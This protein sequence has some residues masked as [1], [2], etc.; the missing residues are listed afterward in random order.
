MVSKLF[1]R[2]LAA[3]NRFLD[4][5]N[6]YA[7]FRNETHASGKG[8]FPFKSRFCINV[9]DD[10][11]FRFSYTLG[12]LRASFGMTC[13]PDEARIGTWFC[14]PGLS[15]FMSSSSWEHYRETIKAIG[16]KMLDL[17]VDDGHIRWTTPFADPD[18][19]RT[20]EPWYY[21]GA[22][23]L[24]EL[25]LGK[26]SFSREQVSQ[27]IAVTI[28][29]P[30]GSYAGVYIVERLTWD[31]PRWFSKS[32]TLATVRCDEGVPIPG[33]GEN[34]YD[35]DQDAIYAHSEDTSDPAQAIGQF[36]TSALQ[37]RF[38]YGGLNWKPEP[39]DPE[40]SPNMPSDTIPALVMVPLSPTEDRPS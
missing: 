36:V 33:K 28:P 23:D 24:G 20:D 19:H 8:E 32:K 1:N 27:P 22:I 34:D 5:H 13:S 2:G 30:E 39:Q 18:N 21:R 40:S 12:E 31:R 38:R 7:W 4:K 17:S 37:W 10:E 9:G 16:H 14:V 15:L 35:L 3:L 26:E 6:G 25:L 11:I 29:M